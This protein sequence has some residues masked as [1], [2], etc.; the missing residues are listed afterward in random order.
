MKCVT[1]KEGKDILQEAH[2]GTCSNHAASRTLGQKGLQVRI[3]LPY[4]S[5]R[6]RST[7]MTMSRM[8]ILHQ[9][10]S[11]AYSQSYHHTS[12]LAIC[13]L[14]FRHDRAALNSARRFYTHLGG[15]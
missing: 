1:T 3:L 9:A 13:M 2:E 15:S 12:I 11:L 8:S 4:S 14:E 6:C 5:I 7:H 10:E